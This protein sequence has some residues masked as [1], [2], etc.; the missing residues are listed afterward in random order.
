MP[1]SVSDW[2]KDAIETMSSS[3]TSSQIIEQIKKI[4]PNLKVS[5]IW[6]SGPNDNPN[7][8]HYTGQAVDFTGPLTDLY[9]TFLILKDNGFVGGIGLGID[10]ADR[11]LHVDLRPE[12]AVWFEV[13]KK[14]DKNG[15]I[16]VV[17]VSESHKGFADALSRASKQY[18]A[19]TPVPAPPLD[20]TD[21]IILGSVALGGLFIITKT[22]K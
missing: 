21:K 2:I 22:S 3:K 13:D 4:N 6:R 16:T 8:Y 10:K 17:T 5:S 11:H 1:G 7:S 18:F 15:M 19:T 20:L 14:T 12:R 9:N